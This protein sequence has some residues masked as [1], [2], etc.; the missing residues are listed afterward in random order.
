MHQVTGRA[1]SIG[2]Q[3]GDGRIEVHVDS[4][5]RTRQTSLRNPRLVV[6]AVDEFL[7]ERFVLH[8]ATAAVGF[9]LGQNLLRSLEACLHLAMLE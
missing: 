8:I 9:D 5:A 3:R 4:A 7:T 1:V 2:G 6:L